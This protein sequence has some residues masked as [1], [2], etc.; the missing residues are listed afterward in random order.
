VSE[1]PVFPKK[2]LIAGIVFLMS[3]VVGVLVATRIHIN[4][5]AKSG[6]N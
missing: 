1:D 3:L 4:V 5:S 6:A 2:G